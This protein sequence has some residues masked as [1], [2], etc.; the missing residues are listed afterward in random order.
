MDKAIDILYHLNY[1]GGE[2]EAFSDGKLKDRAL[3]L[4][5]KLKSP[6]IKRPN[7]I[8]AMYIVLDPKHLMSFGCCYRQKGSDF[9]RDPF[10]ILELHRS[11]SLNGKDWQNSGYETILFKTQNTSNKVKCP[12]VMAVSKSGCFRHSTSLV[13]KSGNHDELA[14]LFVGISGTVPISLL[15]SRGS[16]RKY[17][18]PIPAR[19]CGV[20]L[21]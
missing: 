8:S 5:L 13:V 19:I 3:A 15:Q 20:N 9:L 4:R 12:L 17:D 6:L 10:D 14:S 1:N 7:I 18:H 11:F 16:G 2:N 21:R